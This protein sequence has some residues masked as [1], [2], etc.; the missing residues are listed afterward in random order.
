[1]DDQ[2]TAR[3]TP[4]LTTEHFALQGARSAIS[5]EASGRLSMYLTTVTGGVVSLALVTQ[6]SGLGQAFLIFSLLL[7]P[8]LIYT[9]I[10]TLMRL[11][12]LEAADAIYTQAI[13]RIR[14]FYV[15][16]APGIVEFLSMPYYDD[17]PSTD[18]ARVEVIGYW[19]RILFS[20]VGQVL[21]INSFLAA[22]FTS[23][24]LAR[25]LSFQPASLVIWG[26][27]IFILSALLHALI[28]RSMIRKGY[29]QAGHRFP[30]PEEIPGK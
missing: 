10:S 18:R 16:A 22:V 1:M 14:N 27:V 24:I 2:T 3:I 23:I 8:V 28:V 15:T 26:A 17:N 30:P 12:H 29:S 6:V 11:G 20:A 7:F 5:S 13:N 19:P 21:L 25:L 4:F 9:G